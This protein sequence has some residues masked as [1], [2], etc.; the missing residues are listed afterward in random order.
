MSMRVMNVPLSHLEH[1]QVHYNIQLFV[2]S[3]VKFIFYLYSAKSNTNLQLKST[4]ENRDC[5]FLF[6]A[7]SSS[8]ALSLYFFS[9]DVI[10]KET[11]C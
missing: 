3:I 11:Y 4:N 5:F 2:I 1:F 6:D 7:L 8:R 9:S 10:C